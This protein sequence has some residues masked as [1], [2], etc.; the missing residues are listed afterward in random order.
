MD[1][2]AY[3]VMQLLIVGVKKGLADMLAALVQVNDRGNLE[4]FE[5]FKQ[6]MKIWTTDIS[7]FEDEP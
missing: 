2:L 4:A 3:E 7:Q 6:R 1:I 5:Q